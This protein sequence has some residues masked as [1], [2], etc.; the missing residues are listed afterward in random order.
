MRSISRQISTVALLSLAGC[1]AP[2]EEGAASPDVWLTAV[3]TGIANDAHAIRQDDEGRFQVEL[4]GAGIVAGFGAEGVRIAGR[5]PADAMV[6]R[7]AAWGREGAM[8]T[9]AGVEP[10]SGACAPVAGRDP[11]DACIRQLEYAYD[12]VTAWW[13]GLP[14]GIEQGW[15]VERAPDGAGD[16]VF[17]TEVDGAM[18]LDGDAAGETAWLTDAAGRA[19][20]VSGVTAWDAS[21]APLPALLEVAAFSLRVVVDATD[22]TW[23]V[24]IDPVYTTASTTL[25]GGAAADRFGW[26]AASA[27]DVNHD[28]YDDVV[29]GAPR[30][31]S[32]T[33]RAYVYHGASA[34]VSTT[35]TTTLT[36]GVAGEL[37]GYSV[38]GAGDVNNDTYDDI[39]VGSYGYTSSKGRAYVYHG[40][41]TGIGSTAITTITGATANDQLGF[42]V[43]SAGDVNADN[44][45]DIIVGAPGYS[46]STGRAYVFHGATGGVSTTATSTLTGAASSNFFGYSVAS[47]GNVNGDLYNDVIVGAY[48]NTT[49]TGRAYV[50]LGASSGVSTTAGS[51]FAGSGTNQYFGYSVGSAGDVSG[52]GYDDVVIGAYGV[53]TSTGRVYLYS[54]SSVGLSS[55]AS[56]TIDG[57][58]AG[59]A[60]GTAVA[61]A[62]DVNHDGY[63]DLIVGAP[64]YSSSTGRAYVYH[65]SSLG[66]STTAAAT[67]TGGAGSNYLGNSVASAGDVNGD[68]FDDVIVGA[69]GYSSSTG[70]AYVYRG[71]PEDTDGDGH[72]VD[73][74]CDDGDA[75]V[76]IATSWY[77]D[78]DGD[79]Y[80]SDSASATVACDAPAGSVASHT[81]CA[82][83]VSAINPAATEVCDAANTDEDCDGAADDAD[84]AATGK[85][86]WYADTDA[87]NYGAGAPLEYCDEP[88]GVVMDSADCDDGDAAINP[89]ATE[90]CD[91]ADTDEDC[92]GNADD[93]DGSASG[94]RAY[95]VDGD[96]DSYGAS[97]AISYCDPPA[98]VVENDTDCDDGDAAV[99]P[100]ATEAC[101]AANTDEDCDGLADDADSAAT[102]KGTYYIDGDADSYGSGGALAY[103]DA[104][105]GVS[106]V[107]TDCDDATFA[108]NPG[109]TEACDAA[110]VDEDCD[111]DA[112]DLDTAATGKGVWYVDGDGDSY[113]AG[114]STE[115]CDS[116]SGT[117]TN[118]TDCDDGV[119]AVHPGAT[120]VC[121]AANTDEDCNGDA[122]DADAGATGKSS[123]YVDS[124][125][126]GYGSGTA[127]SLCDAPAAA[128]T[129]HTDC[130]D[131]DARVNPAASEA[132]GDEV[133]SDCDGL[134][135]C[136][137]DLDADG[138]LSESPPTA[139]SLDADCSD[140]GEGSLATPTGD[141]DDADSAYHPGADESDCADPADYNCDGS[142]GYS[143]D[144]GDG[145][146]ACDECDD[147]DKS[148]YPGAS[149][150][151]GDLVDGDC[152]GTDTCYR[153]ADDDGYRPDGVATVVGA[154][155]A[156]DSAGEALA[157][158]PNGDCDDA[159]A[160][161]YPGAS[162]IAGDEL[163]E[164]CD[165]TEVC[166]SD[167]DG[168]GY[169]GES[170]DVVASADIECSG[171]GEASTST[172]TGDCDEASSLVHPGAA[173]TD[174]TDA[175]DYNCDGSV[176]SADDDSDGYAACEE[177]DDAS[178]AVN[179]AA[180]EVCNEVDDDCDVDIDEEATDAVAFYADADGD[181]WTTSASTD[182]CE[183]P[184]GYAEAS[185]SEDC[186]DDEATVYPTATEIADDGIDQDCDGADLEE[187]DTGV[188]DSGDT[189]EPVDTGDTTADTGADTADSAEDPGADKAP[190]ACGCAADTGPGAASLLPALGALLTVRRRRARR[191]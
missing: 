80:G 189:A 100:G 64:G 13:I 142:T 59:D 121:D 55:F 191:A 42:S 103:C 139:A 107:G 180:I 89:A 29:V 118:A 11:A 51:T 165:G 94:K 177:C 172:P 50:Y 87:D 144:D 30:Y 24:T 57:A 15:T 149:E 132:V 160:A 71:Y 167:A 112:D 46:S 179:P 127:S 58:T 67:L 47:A 39:V 78:G 116:P 86:T 161:T 187:E 135:T 26:R 181:L 61:P 173:E 21:G 45:A 91:A 69:Y 65:G 140:T 108:V 92:N 175:T 122:D 79:G 171:T 158:Q 190:E 143:D 137:A 120:E 3:G 54:G 85:G 96:S 178:A 48:G 106:T 40:S 105:A 25:T 153:D 73:V 154:T 7:F 16:L 183:A 88:V 9:L 123:Y 23:P 62:G 66:L 147:T 117:V 17:E 31:T 130:D 90:V 176:G 49:N 126:D 95:Y 155:T 38:A 151:P 174:C 83:A 148:V 37:Y 44:Y 72:T 168:D 133:D 4:P 99:H 35:A 104:P 5:D 109:A 128:S 34:G 162:E 110:N 125:G 124:D 18:A 43:A 60:F 114:A 115:Y 97:A 84:S 152:D 146:A 8:T 157:S 81:D 188:S 12:G 102:G 134:E 129:T 184:D 63:G 185:V 93:A 77:A 131:V 53:T 156:C 166:L 74:D 163:D 119:A 28:G 136:Y 14:N 10:A 182:A 75:S 141:C 36:G 20:V 111:G 56:T 164:D 169:V 41:S 98:D 6:L 33:G 145:Y 2:A 27:G 82:D 32:S 113:G 22:A 101:D 19:W 1:A 138:Y 170:G 70:A 186:D 150:S 52:D 159:D 76:G 68:G